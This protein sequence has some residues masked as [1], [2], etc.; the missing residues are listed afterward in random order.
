[1][2]GLEFIDPAHGLSVDGGP[3]SALY[4][5]DDGGATWR[6]AARP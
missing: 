1:M 3:P 6:R 5:T 2:W 4:L